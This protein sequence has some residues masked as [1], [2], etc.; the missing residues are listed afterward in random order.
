M[1]LP[2]LLLKPLAELE[3]EMMAKKDVPHWHPG[4]TEHEGQG[5]YIPASV[6]NMVSYLLQ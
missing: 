6:V 3:A 2:R 4:P 5:M 1:L